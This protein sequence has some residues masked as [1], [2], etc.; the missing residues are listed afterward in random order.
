[1]R[2]RGLEG[3][4]G[5]SARLHTSSQA[6]VEGDEATCGDASRRAETS[7]RAATSDDASRRVKTC[8]YDEQLSAPPSEVRDRRLNRTVP[9]GAAAIR[10]VVEFAQL[11]L[12][13]AP[14]GLPCGELARAL[15]EAVLRLPEV[16]LAREVLDGGDA[17]A[18]AAGELA[19]E[20]LGARLP[21]DMPDRHSASDGAVSTSKACAR[22]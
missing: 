11:Y 22:C 21:T 10:R 17:V 13:A 9:E 15:A 18:V 4:K 6:I 19:K 20:V 12:H 5:V 8:G 3:L 16:E 14:A 1:V 7:M 2:R